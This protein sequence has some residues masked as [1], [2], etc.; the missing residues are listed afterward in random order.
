MTTIRPHLPS[1][2]GE[3]ASWR[4]KTRAA[5][6]AAWQPCKHCGA[7]NWEPESVKHLDGDT[8]SVRQTCRNCGSKWA[9]G[10]TLG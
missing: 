4:D 7:R 2:E 9:V 10:V 6:I 3:P 1:I 8:Y 5:V